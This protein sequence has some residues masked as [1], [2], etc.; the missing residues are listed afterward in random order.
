[1]PLRKYT[2][3]PIQ[4]RAPNQ[5]FGD[6]QLGQIARLLS[7]QFNINPTTNELSIVM[8]TQAEYQNLENG[9][10][11]G[12]VG[13]SRPGVSS[14]RVPL[15]GNNDCLVYDNDQDAADP[16]NG[17]IMFYKRHAVMFD[18][19]VGERWERRLADGTTELLTG[20]LADVPE[21][22][23]KQGDKLAKQMSGLFQMALYHMAQAMKPEHGSK[24]GGA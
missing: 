11:A 9:E 7:A 5:L 6:Q 16:R 15:Y 17:E 2:P 24:Y 23:M 22:M 8:E 12:P 14:Y 13:T 4:L 10:L 1:M 18:G 19:Q 20:E 3:A 21:P